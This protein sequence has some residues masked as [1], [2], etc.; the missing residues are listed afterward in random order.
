LHFLRIVE[1][2]ETKPSLGE[3]K[4]PLLSHSG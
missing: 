1:A 4:I 3:V 2:D